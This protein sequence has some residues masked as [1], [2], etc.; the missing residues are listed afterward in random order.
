MLGD[1]PIDEE[2]NEDEKAMWRAR[3]ELIGKRKLIKEKHK[4]LANDDVVLHRP[5]KSEFQDTLEKKGV[6]TTF[7]DRRV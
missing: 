7:L 1:E 3:K 6:D 4:L 5:K 2:M